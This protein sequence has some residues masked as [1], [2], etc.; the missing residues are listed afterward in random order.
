MSHDG[1]VFEITE[2]DSPQTQTQTIEYIQQQDALVLEGYLEGNISYRF[3]VRPFNEK[4]ITF[5]VSIASHKRVY[6]TFSSH[7]NEDIYGFGE[8]FSFSTL[9]GQKVPVFVR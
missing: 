3:S 7:P 9:K 5:Q 6:V 1:G 2:T 4:Q 8:Q